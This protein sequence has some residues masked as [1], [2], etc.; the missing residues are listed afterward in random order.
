MVFSLLDATD[1][2]ANPTHVLANLFAFHP[3]RGRQVQHVVEDIRIFVVKD[4]PKTL[5]SGIDGAGANGN[6]QLHV[7]SSFTQHKD[8]IRFYYLKVKQILFL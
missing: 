1:G 5:G 7:L 3:Q 4:S 8:S 6:L 2:V